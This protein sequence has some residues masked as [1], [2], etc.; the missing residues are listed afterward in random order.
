M[1]YPYP[2]IDC[3]R[4]GKQLAYI[5]CVH[6]TRRGAPITQYVPANEIEAG[7]ALCAHCHEYKDK[8]SVDDLQTIC[9]VSLREMLHGGSKIH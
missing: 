8:L 2:Y 6:V 7:E 9:E 1:K 3:P 4:H 5:V